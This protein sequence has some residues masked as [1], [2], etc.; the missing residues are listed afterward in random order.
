MPVLGPRSMMGLCWRCRG[1]LGGKPS[2]IDESRDGHSQYLLWTA[3]S[4]SD[5][6][7]SPVAISATGGPRRVIS[8]LSAFHFDGVNAWFAKAIDRNKSVVATWLTENGNPNWRALCDI[9]YVFHLPLQD[10]ISG[11]TDGV[12]VSSIRP[13]PLSI[14]SRP[15][16]KRPQSLDIEQVRAFF[17]QVKKGQHPGIFTMADVARRL[18]TFPRE[19]R[20]VASEESMI[21]SKALLARRLARSEQR[22]SDRR[23]SLM[24]LLRKTLRRM[25]EEG[26]APTRRAVEAALQLTG[27]RIQRSEV[28]LIK[29]IL[30]EARPLAPEQSRS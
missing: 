20:R 22:A 12:L 8:S 1:W 17:E 27:Q 11:D 19:L 21:L 28:P 30:D 23:A 2:P 9:S 5:L 25:A 3:R 4:F 6:L 16:K 14:A 10:L 15:A 29:A 18:N 26:V 7:E 24:E 13:L